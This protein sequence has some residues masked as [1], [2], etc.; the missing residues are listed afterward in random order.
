[1]RSRNHF[2]RRKAVIIY[3]LSS[4]QSA[5]AALCCHLRP[6]WFYSIFLHYHIK[7][8]LQKTLLNLKSVFWFPVQLLSE[9]FITPRRLQRDIIVRVHVSSDKYPLFLS[10]FNENLNF[11]DR[12]KK[13]VITFHENPSSGSQ[14]V[15]CGR[16]DRHGEASSRFRS[17]ANALKNLCINK[18][19]WQHEITAGSVNMEYITGNMY[20]A[21]GRLQT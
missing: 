4:R 8:N 19:N 21:V 12:F 18:M 2:R 10:Y 15:L 17:F 20:E 13:V 9:T 1:M 11:L 14:A 16:T 6:V 7:N 5:F 3:E